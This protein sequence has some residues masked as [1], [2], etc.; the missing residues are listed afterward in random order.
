[1]IPRVVSEIQGGSEFAP[2]SPADVVYALLL[3]DE[4]VFLGNHFPIHDFKMFWIKI[5]LPLHPKVE[6]GNERLI[7][8]GKVVKIDYVEAD[9]DFRGLIRGRGY[10]GRGYR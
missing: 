3:P 8:D 5:P 6:V 1:M 2:A 7:F 9:L 10:G 4:R